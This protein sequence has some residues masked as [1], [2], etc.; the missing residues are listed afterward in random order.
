MPRHTLTAT[1]G[2]FLAS[3]FLE[4]YAFEELYALDVV[5]DRQGVR[6]RV[7]NNNAFVDVHIMYGTT[8]I[9]VTGIS[10]RLAEEVTS[11][12][13][14]FPNYKIRISKALR[15]RTVF[16]ERYSDNN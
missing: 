4:H 11:R 12:M 7:R 15:N 8:T 9:L 16:P 5:I 3:Q 6:I 13:K 10:P 14:K 2:E 1:D